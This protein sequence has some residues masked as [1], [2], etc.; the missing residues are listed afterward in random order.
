MKRRIFFHGHDDPKR[1]RTTDQEYMNYEVDMPPLHNTPFASIAKG[2]QSFFLN[3][4]CE[5]NNMEID[6]EIP[7]CIKCH[8]VKEVLPGPD[9]DPLCRRCV[10][11][12]YCRVIN[13]K[14]HYFLSDRHIAHLRRYKPSSE[15]P[16]V[17]VL[18]SEVEKVAL[19]I[20]RHVHWSVLAQFQERRRSEYLRSACDWSEV[21]SMLN[22]FDTIDPY[23]FAE[24][25]MRLHPPTLHQSLCFQ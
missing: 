15:Y 20:H 6:D 13:A 16:A 25:Y 23:L 9:A 24:E 4:S 12:Y 22:K 7:T 10:T 19:K 18:E 2:A 11:N 8:K 3:G 5:N 21:E 17:Y 14:N 1:F